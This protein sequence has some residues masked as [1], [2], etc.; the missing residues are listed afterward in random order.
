MF[1]FN[2]KILSYSS[3]ELGSL[4][5]PDFRSAKVKNSTGL[6]KGLKGCDKNGSFHFH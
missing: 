3:D 1:I 5:H 4:A 2:I 6:R